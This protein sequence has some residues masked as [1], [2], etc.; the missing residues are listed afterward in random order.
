LKDLAALQEV[1]STFDKI[2]PRILALT[3]CSTLVAQAQ[4]VLLQLQE[5]QRVNELLKHML[6][7]VQG[8]A[9]FPNNPQLKVLL[10]QAEA[11]G[12]TS[13]TAKASEARYCTVAKVLEAKDCLTDAIQQRN[14]E[15]KTV[16]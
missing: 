2:T 12:L 8:E 11:V 6:K 10:Q 16:F 13:D 3:T 7:T 4:A 14:Q 1:L 15:G 5:Q 9:L